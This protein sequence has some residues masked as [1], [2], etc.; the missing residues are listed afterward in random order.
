M[1]FSSVSVNL[2]QVV[3]G[4]PH[5][6]F[7]SGVQ[8]RPYKLRSKRGVVAHRESYYHPRSGPLSGYQSSCTVKFLCRF[9]LSPNSLRGVTSPLLTRV[10]L[11]LGC[12]ASKSP[13]WE[14]LQYRLGYGVKKTCSVILCVHLELIPLRGSFQHF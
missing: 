13:Q 10:F 14:L 9:L 7:P 11:T 6:L 1:V 12:S 3:L 8:N 2:L 5:C 4:L